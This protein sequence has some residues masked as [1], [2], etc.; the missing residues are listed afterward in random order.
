MYNI[1]LLINET[2]DKT[3]VG[4]TNRLEK[5]IK[6]HRLQKVRSTKNFGKFKYLLLDT[7]DTLELARYK[8]ILGILCGKK[9][10]KK[11]TFKNQG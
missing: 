5:R 1:Y 11:Y 7:A 10:N 6:E 2:F 8:K 9:K 4:L 3:Y